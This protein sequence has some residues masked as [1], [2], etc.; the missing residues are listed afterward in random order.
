MVSA[1]SSEQ[2]LVLGAQVTDARRWKKNARFEQ[3]KLQQWSQCD[4]PQSP[5]N[6]IALV[7]RNGCN[8]SQSKAYQM[9][10]QCLRITLD[11]WQGAAEETAVGQQKHR[12]WRCNIQKTAL[13]RRMLHRQVQ[14]LGNQCKDKR[15]LR[16]KL[17]PADHLDM[18]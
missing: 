5:S 18:W 9:L 14:K 10:D 17:F 16:F 1:W 6:R 8:P 12:T 7:C 2:R 13:Y 4:L 15:F 11:R 3:G